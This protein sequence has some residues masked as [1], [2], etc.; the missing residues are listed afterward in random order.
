[1]A[2]NGTIDKPKHELDE[3]RINPKQGLKITIH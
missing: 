3:N 1:M 2:K